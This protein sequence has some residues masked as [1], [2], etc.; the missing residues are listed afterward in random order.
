FSCR[1]ANPLPCSLAE[2]LMTTLSS[3][4]GNTEKYFL[5]ESI[6]IPLIFLTGALSAGISSLFIFILIK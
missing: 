3:S 5:P 2:N 1:S 6:Y 4:N